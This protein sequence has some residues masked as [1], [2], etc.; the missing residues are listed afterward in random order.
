MTLN[1]RNKSKSIPVNVSSFSIDRQTI[2][3]VFVLLEST[4]MNFNFSR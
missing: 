3:E 2:F 4:T 1:S